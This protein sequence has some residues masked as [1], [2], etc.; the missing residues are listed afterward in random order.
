MTLFWSFEMSI[1]TVVM[2]FNCYVNGKD[3]E[4][5]SVN[6]PEN[7]I[8]KMA[9]EA[10]DIVINSTRRGNIVLDDDIVFKYLF[11]GVLYQRK[12]K[13]TSMWSLV[14]KE[15]LYHFNTAIYDYNKPIYDEEERMRLEFEKRKEES[16]YQCY[17]HLKERFKDRTK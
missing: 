8:D 7:T 4:V 12:P 17:L 13:D 5:F 14:T 10:A 15:F 3:M 9:K 6:L 2:M 16:D 11:D 1:F